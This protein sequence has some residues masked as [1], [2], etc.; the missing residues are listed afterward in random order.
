MLMLS[1]K[2]AARRAKF[3]AITA[4]IEERAQQKEM[5]IARDRVRGVGSRT[6]GRVAPPRTGPTPEDLHWRESVLNRDGYKCVDCGST[7]HL[8]ADHIKPKAIYPELKH[9]VSNGRTLCH[10]CH[11]QTETY[12]SKVHRI[13]AV[14]VEQL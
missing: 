5:W 8:E 11:V 13:A 10:P 2:K 4:A 12:G 1:D 9:D 3:Q 14:S 7:E 6:T